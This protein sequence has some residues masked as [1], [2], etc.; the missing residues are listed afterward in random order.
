MRDPLDEMLAK[1]PRDVAVPRDLWPQ[2]ERRIKRRPR[3]WA[4]IAVAASVVVCMGGLVTWAV[5]H[6]SPTVSDRRNAIARLDVFDEPND[7]GYLAARAE[8]EESFNERLPMLE[9]NTRS[10]VER[11]LALVR[12][13]H[14]DIR[15][16][17]ADQPSDAVLQHLFESTLHAEFDL[18]DNVVRGTQPSISRI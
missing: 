9:P 12:R 17:L 8:L 1:L 15:R 10:K 16:A 3:S 13:A 14:D 5:L 2:I 4:A 11:D 6:S 18:Y 7:P